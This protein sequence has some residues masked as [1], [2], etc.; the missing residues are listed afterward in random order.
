MAADEENGAERRRRSAVLL[1]VRADP[2]R[3]AARRT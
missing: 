1:R 2:V 3:S